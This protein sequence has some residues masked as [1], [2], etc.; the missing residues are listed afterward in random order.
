[1]EG[2]V[3]TFGLMWMLLLFCDVE[4]LGLDDVL[5]FIVEGLGLDCGVLIIMDG[6]LCVF[7]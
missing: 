3:L 7:V 4:G 2:V 1:M 5:S 6:M